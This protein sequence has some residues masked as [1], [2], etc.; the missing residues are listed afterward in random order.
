M[1]TTQM[2]PLLTERFLAR[3]SPI[4][5][6]R[7]NGYAR[8]KRLVWRCLTGGTRRAKRVFD[9]GVT[10]LL[11]LLLSPLFLLI[12]LLI[13][14]EDG[15][16]VFFVQTRV[17]KW[18]RHF[19]M[20]KFRSM[21]LDAEQRLQELL[22]HNE[23]RE[24][25]TFKMKNDPR[26][27]RVGKWLRRLSFDELPQLLNVLNGDMSLVGPRPYLPNETERMGDFA[28]TILKAPPG[29]TGLWQVSGRNELTFDQRLRLDEYYVRNWSL[30]MDII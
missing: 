12:A 30:W 8:L 19:K 14:L 7:L 17:G 11:L 18:G 13:K 28:A 26:I 16:P 6:W 29:L 21:Y 24:G 22:A 20:F 10:F 4:G 27:T 5:R 25:V 23:H 1:S 2:D 9:A 15:G 3:Q